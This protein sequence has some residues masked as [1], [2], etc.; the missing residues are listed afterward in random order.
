MSWCVRC[1]GNGRG[2]RLGD[3]RHPP[4]RAQSVLGRVGLLPHLS[5][6]RGTRDDVE[7]GKPH[8]Q[9]HL[10]AA[11]RIGHAPAECL[12]LEDSAP[13]L[14]AAHAAG[15]ITVAAGDTPPPHHVAVLCRCVVS[16]PGGLA[17]P[18]AAMAAS[19]PMNIVIFGLAVSSS[20]GNGHAALWRGLIRGLLQDGHRVTFFERD[21]TFY[22]AEPRPDRAAAGRRACALPGLGQRTAASPPRRGRGRRRHGHLLLPGRA[23]RLGP[24][25]AAAAP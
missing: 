19:G 12:A 3:Q 14:L 6:R 17:R 25:R 13:G 1:I 21:Q 23:G 8:P 4:H 18:S 7:H 5:A 22:A 24:D 9:T 2:L 10:L 16:Q 20:W 11:A 15:M